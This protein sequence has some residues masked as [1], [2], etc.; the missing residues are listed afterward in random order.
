MRCLCLEIFGKRTRCVFFGPLMTKHGHIVRNIQVQ[1]LLRRNFFK[2]HTT[3]ENVLVPRI[4]YGTVD[5]EEKIGDNNHVSSMTDRLTLKSIAVTGSRLII[6]PACNYRMQYYGQRSMGENII[7]PQSRSVRFKFFGIGQLRY[8][9][10]S[11]LAENDGRRV[12][13]VYKL[14]SATKFRAETNLQ[15]FCLSCH[16]FPEDSNLRSFM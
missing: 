8:Q 4:K 11:V 6:I 9:L 15:S 2:V 16:W 14:W 1:D 3:V 12:R 5:V 13:T 10:P 7:I